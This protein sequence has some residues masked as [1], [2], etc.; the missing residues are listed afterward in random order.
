M[1]VPV[2]QERFREIP[3]TI[4]APQQQADAGDTAIAFHMPSET[5]YELVIPPFLAEVGIEKFLTH[6]LLE[7]HSCCD[8]PGR[9]AEPFVV[10]CP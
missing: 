7:F 9:H 6:C 1:T 2:S 8:V 4:A 10:M 5:M 3:M